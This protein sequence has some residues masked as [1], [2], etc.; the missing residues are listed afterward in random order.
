MKLHSVL[1]TKIFL[2]AIYRLIRPVWRDWMIGW[3]TGEEI[4]HEEDGVFIDM[5]TPEFKTPDYRAKRKY[6]N[7]ELLNSHKIVAY[8]APVKYHLEDILPYLKLL[9]VTCNAHHIQGEID[10]LHSLYEDIQEEPL[11]VFIFRNGVAVF[12]NC[13]N[14]NI[15]YVM[16]ILSAFQTV[17]YNIKNRIISDITYYKASKTQ[18]SSVGTDGIFI[19]PHKNNFYE[20]YAT[21]CMLAT[22][23]SLT[24]WQKIVENNLEII[25]ERAARDINMGCT[26][27]ATE[28]DI[29]QLN[30]NLSTV[31]YFMEIND[32]VYQPANEDGKRNVNQ[33]HR[34]L[35]ILSSISRRIKNLEKHLYNYKEICGLIE[36]F[37]SYKSHTYVLIMYYMI[38]IST[39]LLNI[40]KYFNKIQETEAEKLQKKLALQNKQK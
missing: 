21:S 18:H 7:V 20:K 36:V 24:I 13:N 28:R 9:P 3:Y 11:E 40:L 5:E 31:I 33:Y 19:I 6:S 35:C 32:Q 16:A 14:E 8:G 17:G 2:P 34:D 1:H 15:D 4:K 12:W 25:L 39:L 30:K 38:T 29:E 26:I 10:I 22:S 37:Y 27:S 23:L